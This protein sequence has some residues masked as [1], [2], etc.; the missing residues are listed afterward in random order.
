MSPEVVRRR[1]R[2][3]VRVATTLL[4]IVGI[5]VAA[6]SFAAYGWSRMDTECRQPDIIPVGS[7][8]TA[9]QFSWSWRPLGFTCTWP[10]QDSSD[11]TETRLWW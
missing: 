7:T 2:A 5:A 10:V 11:V 4:V 1:T 9:V 6:L 8:A 3:L